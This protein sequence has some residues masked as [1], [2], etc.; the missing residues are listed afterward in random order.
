M[1]LQDDRSDLTLDR[2]RQ[3][4]AVVTGWC[5]DHGS[6]KCDTSRPTKLDRIQL[7]YL[8]KAKKLKC[9]VCRKP[10]AGVRVTRFFNMMTGHR[11][12]ADWW[13]DED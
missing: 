3:L 11:V 12:I 10:L 7:D 9:Q 2:C 1:P 8:W 6:R 5:A 4:N 13:A